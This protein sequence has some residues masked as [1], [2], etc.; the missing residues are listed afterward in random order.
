MHAWNGS[1]CGVM[2]FW[3]W[4]GDL[5]GRLCHAVWIPPG[6]LL[7]SLGASWV[8]L[9]VLYG[10]STGSYWSLIGPLRCVVWELS[11]GL[12]VLLCVVPGASWV[13]RLVGDC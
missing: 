6:A 9:G 10:C 12:L 1:V 2:G 3:S 5:L 7:A 8:L 13:C 11:W 4:I